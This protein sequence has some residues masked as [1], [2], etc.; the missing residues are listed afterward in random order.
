M[1]GSDLER[2]RHASDA[3]RH[4][5]HVTRH[6]AYPKARLREP[7]PLS[8]VPAYMLQK[9]QRRKD[10][11]SHASVGRRAHCRQRVRHWVTHLEQR[12]A[13]QHARADANHKTHDP[14]QKA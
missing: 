3:T 14:F 4:T 12:L 9:K 1:H 7:Q 13:L 10:A 6:L 8:I 2:K 5:S 11:D